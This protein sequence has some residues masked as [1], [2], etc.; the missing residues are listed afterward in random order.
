MAVKLILVWDSN[1]FSLSL[2]TAL[3]FCFCHFLCQRGAR[4]GG[5]SES[6][7]S[8]T[9]GVGCTGWESTSKRRA[10]KQGQSIRWPTVTSCALTQQHRD[11]GRSSFTG[12]QGEFNWK[13]MS[14][15]FEDSRLERSCEDRNMDQ[16][17]IKRL[18]VK[19]SDHKVFSAVERRIYINIIYITYLED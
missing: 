5:S 1:S 8:A 7:Q 13:I 14:E 15:I 18:E 9:Q 6:Y 17:V 16:R 19:W 12:I 11:S 4:R 3:T 2:K 10:L